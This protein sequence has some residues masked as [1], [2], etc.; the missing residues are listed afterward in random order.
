[1][2]H[3]LVR[4]AD[5]VTQPWKNGGGVTRELWREP[6]DGEF[7][8]RLSIADVAAA[9][10]FSQ[11]PGVDRVITLLEGAG[12]ALRGPAGAHRVTEVGAPLAFRGEDA[13]DCTLLEGPVRDFNVMV[14]RGRPAR[15]GMASV[16]PLPRSGWCLALAPAVELQIAGERVEL[17]R[18]DLAVWH[19]E[20]STLVG[21]RALVVEVGRG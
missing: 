11:F 20:G 13:W 12:F 18:W 5:V 1:M 7:T 4:F 10:P 8:V 15:V 19:D 9:G 2:P 6:P 14:R 16:G 17:G 21:G 3:S